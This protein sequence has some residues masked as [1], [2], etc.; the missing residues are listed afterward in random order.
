MAFFDLLLKLL[1][2]WEVRTTSCLEDCNDAVKLGLL[3]LDVKD[4]EVGSATSP[5]LDLIQ[6]TG[7]LSTVL[8]MLV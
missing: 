2:T 1:E 8:R 6:G 4:V 5:M 7:G 3:K